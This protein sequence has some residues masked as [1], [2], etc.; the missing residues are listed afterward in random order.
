MKISSFLSR[1]YPK[2]TLWIVPSL[3]DSTTINQNWNKLRDWHYKFWPSI[4]Y[5]F[6]TDEFFWYVAA[7][8]WSKRFFLADLM[9]QKGW[10]DMLVICYHDNIAFITLIYC[11][12][13]NLIVWI[14]LYHQVVD[15]AFRKK[16][17]NKYFLS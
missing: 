16:N 7:V 14:F 3:R 9:E 15:R 17:L 5:V 1:V 2:E 6:S 13:Y 10:N 8:P 4:C 11:I 12:F